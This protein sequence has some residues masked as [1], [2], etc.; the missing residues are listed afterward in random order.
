MTALRDYQCD[1]VSK[2][3]AASEGCDRRLILVAPTGAGKTVIAA[4]II[5]SG[6]ARGERVLF[7]AHR[8]ELIRQA[9]AK[10]HGLSIDHGIIL[11]GFPTRPS[12]PVQVASV[13]TVWSRAMRSVVMDLPPAELVIVD[14]CHHSRAKT[15]QKI[16]ES[17]PHA[18]LLGMTATPCRGDGRGL[19]NVF[20][21]IVECPPVADLVRLGYLVPTRVYAPTRPDLK[22]IRV[23]RGEYVERQLAERMDQSQLVGDIVS[24]WHRLAERRKTVVFA[25]SVAH[26]VHLRDEFRRSGVWAEHLDGSTPAEER[27]AILERLSAGHVELVC[28]CMV[29]TEGWDQPDVSCLI[30][31]RPTK[32]VGLYRQM[33]GRVLRPAPGKTDALVLDHAGAVFEHGLIDEP[34]TWTLDAD[35]RAEHPVQAARRKGS[36]LRLVTCPECHA[37]R[38]SGKPCDACGWQPRPRPIAPD[39]ID[40]ELG[41]FDRARGVQRLQSSPAERTRFYRQLLWIAGERGY[42]RG[43]AAHKYRE[44][45]GA[46]P[47]AYNPEP[48]P[49]EPAVLSWVRS[50]QIAY[51]KAMAKRKGAA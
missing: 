31:A 19:G 28:N 5:R 34:V 47:E 25:S 10:L 46:W 35:R 23:E 26:S 22:G 29:L 18:L 27:D 38:F 15:Y 6:T 37:V 12:A 11:A 45:F 3:A 14:E 32:H 48:L 41:R 8:R 42:K 4:D 51:A 13:Q 36:A 2:I 43:W 20:D 50:R 21:R 39:V 49:A 24:H 33:M 17:Y 40:G 7:L 30:L 1:V 9:S 44:K 16:I